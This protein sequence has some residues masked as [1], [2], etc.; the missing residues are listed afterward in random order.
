MSRNGV[1]RNAPFLKIRIVPACSTTKSR[2]EPSSALATCIG[3]ET[4]PGSAVSTMDGAHR[5]A[6]P[7]PSTRGPTGDPPD[8]SAPFEGPPAA[9][10]ESP[11]HEARALVEMVEGGRVRVGREGALRPREDA[12]VAQRA[13]EPELVEQAVVGGAGVVLLGAE[14]EERIVRDRAAVASS[15]YETSPSGPSACALED[16]VDEQPQR[17]RPSAGVRRRRGA[18]GRR[19]RRVAPQIVR[20]PVPSPLTPKTTTGRPRPR[21]RTCGR[22]RCGRGRRGRCRSTSGIRAAGDR[23]GGVVGGGGLHPE[24][25]REVPGADVGRRAGVRVGGIV[26]RDLDAVDVAE[27]PLPWKRSDVAANAEAPRDRATAKS[28]AATRTARDTVAL[29]FMVL[30]F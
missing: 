13:G 29:I 30:E 18:T 19:A 20:S 14:D 7:W 12:R 27:V 5:A 21:R 25:D 28:A 3:A 26:H 6:R 4:D 8:A 1:A 9:P 23:A 24:L 22:R 2:A 10:D 17:S 11:H 16:P 15:G